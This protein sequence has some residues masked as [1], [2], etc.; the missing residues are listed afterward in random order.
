MENHITIATSRGN[1]KMTHAA[2]LIRKLF[3]KAIKGDLK[4]AQLLLDKM[5]AAIERRA[6][7]ADTAQDTLDP[8]EDALLQAIL[9]SLRPALQAGGEA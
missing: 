5:A 3:E 2:A 4:A 9:S 6:G 8:A 7:R 1:E